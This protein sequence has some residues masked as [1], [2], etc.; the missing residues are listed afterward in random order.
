MGLD[1]AHP[2]GAHLL[3]PGHPVRL[4]TSPEIDQPWEFA[5]L[6]GDHELAASL[7]R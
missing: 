7:E 2:T 3:E 5:L 1:L 4:G 6:D